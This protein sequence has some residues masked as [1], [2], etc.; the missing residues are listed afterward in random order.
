MH[1]EL[2][3]NSEKSII[4]VIFSS[5][6]SAAFI[7]ELVAVLG[8]LSFGKDVLGNIILMCKCLVFVAIQHDRLN[9]IFFHIYI[10]YRPSISFCR[11]WKI[12]NC[13]FSHF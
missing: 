2:Q 9:I 6:G 11:L 10:Y 4:K 12:G 1:N 7:Y 8:Y 5:I 3:D 13:H